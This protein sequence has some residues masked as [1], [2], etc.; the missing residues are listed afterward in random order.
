MADDRR[1]IIIRKVQ[2]RGGHHSGQWKIAYADFVTAMM[3][4]FLLMWLLSSSSEA[5]LRGISEYFQAPLEVLADGTGGSGSIIQGGGKDLTR[6]DRETR[7]YAGEALGKPISAKVA[8]AELE[9]LDM[10][11]FKNLKRRLEQL[12]E[13]NPTMRQFRKQLLLD[14]TTE[15]LRVQII[16]YYLLFI[17]GSVY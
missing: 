16:N 17:S 4:F 1:P 9:R 13:T 10:I 11:R 3:A 7:K 8:Q 14:I 2:K 5:E 15:G 12:I 6:R